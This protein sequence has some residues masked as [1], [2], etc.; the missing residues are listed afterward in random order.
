MFFGSGEIIF[1]EV[2]QVKVNDMDFILLGE[3]LKFILENSM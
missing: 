3:E 1:V 2:G